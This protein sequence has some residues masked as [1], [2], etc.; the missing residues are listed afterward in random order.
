MRIKKNTGPVRMKNDSGD[1]ATT[2][3]AD[4]TVAF[5]VLERARRVLIVDDNRDN[6]LTLGILTRSEGYEVRL[7]HS[8]ATGLA[9]AKE[10]RPDV[11]IIDLAMPGL[12]GFDVAK[13][14]RSHYGRNCPVLIAITAMDLP[15][16]RQ[17]AEVSGFQYFVGKPYNPQAL[18]ELL[19]S[20]MAK[21]PGPASQ[22]A[23]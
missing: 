5:P 23:A 7:A 11:A 20:T 16:E 22:P 4:A 9:Q 19:A 21:A 6:L 13:E 14:L 15:I 10:A 8:G 12:T 17:R 2:M 1:S 18:L 3:T